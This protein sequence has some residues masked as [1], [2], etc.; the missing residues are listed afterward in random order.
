MLSEEERRE[1]KLTMWPYAVGPDFFK[2]LREEMLSATYEGAAGPHGFA[3][4]TGEDVKGLSSSTKKVHKYGMKL[5]MTWEAVAGSQRK[6]HYEPTGNKYTQWLSWWVGKQV[7]R[8]WQFVERRLSKFRHYESVS[9]YEWED[10]EYREF[11]QK[12]KWVEDEED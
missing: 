11:S 4:M 12:R 3:G 9:G 5:P 10:A 8:F 7:F 1:A 6:G 2:G